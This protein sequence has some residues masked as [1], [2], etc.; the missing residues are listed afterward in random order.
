MHQ[1]CA[2]YSSGVPLTS[3][4]SQ[5]KQIE[6]NQKQIETISFGGVPLTPA[7]CPDIL[8]HRHTDT[9]THRHRHTDTRTHRQTHRHTDT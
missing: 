7:V 1:R 9:Q 6:A 8:T 4:G 2:A 5:P 3:N